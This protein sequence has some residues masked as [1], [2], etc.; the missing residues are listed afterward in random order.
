[1]IVPFVIEGKVT[2]EHNNQSLPGLLYRLGTDSPSFSTF[3]EDEH[4]VPQEYHN[5]VTLDPSLVRWALKGCMLL[6]AALVVWTCRT[7]TSFSGQS[8]RLAAEFSIILIGM[9]L[10]SERT[11]KHHCVT[12]VL[13]FAV[14]CYYLFVC[15]PGQGLQTYLIGSLVAVLLLMASTST[16]LLPANAAKLAQVYG[17]YVWANLI[18]LS[19]LI[20]LLRV[21]AASTQRR[22]CSAADCVL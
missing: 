17:A 8:W 22:P 15:Q 5:L 16:G 21:D 12:L 1:M 14:L 19:A 2:S 9:L 13:P 20:V 18:L 11:W 4:Y 7:P 3:D 6:F 10:F